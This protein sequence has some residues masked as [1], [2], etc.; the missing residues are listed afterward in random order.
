MGCFEDPSTPC[1][2]LQEEL[3][4]DAHV[5][6]VSIDAAVGA[7][8]QA[9]LRRRQR[10]VHGEPR[11]AGQTDPQRRAARAAEHRRAWRVGGAKSLKPIGYT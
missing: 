6:H 11:C 7:A 1:S 5:L 10:I 3:V 4:C 8:A 2:H 9:A